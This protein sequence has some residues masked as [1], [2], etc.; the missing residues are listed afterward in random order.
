[1]LVIGYRYRLPIVPPMLVLAGGAFNRRRVGGA[2]LILLVAAIAFGVTHIRKHEPSHDFSEE[3]A[4]S[5]LALR[6][7]GNLG[8]AREAARRGVAVNP[9]SS[10]AWLTLGDI[11]AS[12]D[13]WTAAENAWLRAIQADPDTARAWS[14]LA[15]ARIRRG[16][17]SG[18]DAALVRSISI[19]PETEALEN[20]TTLRSRR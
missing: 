3:W 6:K 18:A 5:A 1:M 17:M 20:L 7:E 4:M 12:R 13:D 16:D 15:L 11:E 14:H 9:K 19:R 8:E 2:P 10:L